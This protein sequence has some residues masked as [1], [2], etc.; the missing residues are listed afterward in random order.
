MNYW[1]LKVAANSLTTYEG[2]TVTAEGCLT[3]SSATGETLPGARA[4]EKQ[5]HCAQL[6]NQNTQDDK[7]V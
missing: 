4:V 2:G 6:L 7:I 3:E 1:G 5:Q